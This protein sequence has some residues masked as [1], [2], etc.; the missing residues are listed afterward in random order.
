MISWFLSSGDNM[1]SRVSES[2]WSDQDEDTTEQGAGGNQDLGAGGDT[3]EAKVL[4]G[5]KVETDL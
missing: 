4:V 1:A 3:V 2:L 5:D